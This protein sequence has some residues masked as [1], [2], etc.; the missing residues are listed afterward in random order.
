MTTETTTA[1][2]N[3]QTDWPCGSNIHCNSWRRRKTC[4]LYSCHRKRQL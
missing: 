1:V 4:R 3:R 2:K